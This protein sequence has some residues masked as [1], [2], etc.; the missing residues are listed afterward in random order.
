VASL[1][2]STLKAKGNQNDAASGEVE[3]MKVP[4]SQGED[5]KRDDLSVGRLKCFERS[6]EDRVGS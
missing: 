3:G 2:S 4:K 6:M 1:K 5:Q